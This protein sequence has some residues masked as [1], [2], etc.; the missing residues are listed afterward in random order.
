M[1]VASGLDLLKS[2]GSGVLP[3]GVES[4]ISKGTSLDR[5][6]FAELLSKARAGGIESGLNVTVAS[7][8]GVT[9][10]DDQLERLS[11]AADLAESQGATQAVVFIDGKTLRLDVTSRTVLGEVDLSA[12]G[13]V[14]ELDAV[15]SIPSD[16]KDARPSASTVPVPDRGVLGLTPETLAALAQAQN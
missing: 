10:S 2:L 7:G 11:K 9:L 14:T 13:V 6:G 1:K 5:L 16:S 4:R 15:I 3:P 12:G 8:A